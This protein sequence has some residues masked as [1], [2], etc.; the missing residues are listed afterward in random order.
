MKEIL[1]WGIIV[2]NKN[3]VRENSFQS[4]QR[5]K[6]NIYQKIIDKKNELIKIYYS[7]FRTPMTV[8]KYSK[9]DIIE[10]GYCLKAG[11]TALTNNIFLQKL[12]EVIFDNGKRA[13][14]IIGGSI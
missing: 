10:F 7:R 12:V 3:T 5:S 9:K 2:Y 6:N 1:T 4:F 8:I 13:N 11:K 14:N